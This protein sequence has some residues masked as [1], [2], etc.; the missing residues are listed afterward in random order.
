MSGTTGPYV[1]PE[2]DYATCGCG[3][4]FVVYRSY[5]WLSIWSSNEE[6]CRGVVLPLFKQYG[7]CGGRHLCPQCLWGLKEEF[8]MRRTRKKA[9]DAAV[10]T[11]DEPAL[12]PETPTEETAVSEE[13]EF[14]WDGGTD[15]AQPDGGG[16][17]VT[18]DAPTEEAPSADAPATDTPATTEEP[19]QTLQ[20]EFPLH[21]VVKYIRTD[22]KGAWGTVEGHV[23]KRNVLYLQVKL[24]HFANGK[25][26][27]E[28]KQTM[29]DVRPSSVELS[30]AP[31]E[32]PVE[33]PAA[34]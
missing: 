8:E 3:I 26:R 30:E 2:S 33:E 5:R 1:I 16:N 21:S 34:S 27:P 15:E 23:D 28:D 9:P 25:A 12:V 14:S 31:A 10:A 17:V 22:W 20:E 32:Q 24:T 11:E 18:A 19:K 6:L 4:R 29:T 13:Q 7:K